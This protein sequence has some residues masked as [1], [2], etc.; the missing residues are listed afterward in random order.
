MS[1]ELIAAARAVLALCDDPDADIYVDAPAAIERLRAAVN[2]I[3]PPD[4]TPWCSYGH[5]REQDCDCGPL[6]DND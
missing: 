5:M 2:A 1:A 4:P 6:A 3:D